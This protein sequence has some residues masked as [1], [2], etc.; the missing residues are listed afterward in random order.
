MQNILLSSCFI[1]CICFYFLTLHQRK[2]QRGAVLSQNKRRTENVILAH[3]PQMKRLLSSYDSFFVLQ[4]VKFSRIV[5][6]LGNIV[7]FSLPPYYF[8]I[9][10]VQ[11]RRLSIVHFLLQKW[12]FQRNVVL[13]D[14]SLKSL[15]V[16]MLYKCLNISLI[17]VDL[18][19]SF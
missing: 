3:T 6:L 11:F 15:F 18:I 12:M 1:V 2:E 14:Q 7:F 9:V 16:H 13:F 19:S 8:L 10:W 5:L 17:G 4:F